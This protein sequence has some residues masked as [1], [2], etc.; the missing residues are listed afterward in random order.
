MG[1]ELK[2][3]AKGLFIGLFFVS[4]YIGIMYFAAYVLG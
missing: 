3:L 2:D 4:I 1:E